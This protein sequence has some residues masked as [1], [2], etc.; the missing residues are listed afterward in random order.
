[1]PLV[2]KRVFASRLC[3]VDALHAVLEELLRIAEPGAARAGA[4][5]AHGV[6]SATEP[7]R[8]ARGRRANSRR[9]HCSA[10]SRR[11][12]AAR[13]ARRTDRGSRRR[14]RRAVGAS[15][16]RGGAGAACSAELGG[17]R[18]VGSS[19]S[20]SSALSFA[21][22]GGAAA[23]LAACVRGRVSAGVAPRRR[24]RA[25]A[26]AGWGLRCGARCGGAPSRQPWQPRPSPSPHPSGGACTRC[27]AAGRA[28][29]PHVRCQ[30]AAERGGKPG[31]HLLDSFSPGNSGY[32][33]PA[34]ASSAIVT[35][36]GAPK[37]GRN[38]CRPTKTRPLRRHEALPAHHQRG[39]GGCLAA[40]RR[41]ARSCAQRAQQPGS[42][43]C[44]A[45][46]AA[47]GGRRGAAV[48]LLLSHQHGADV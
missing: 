45:S 15:G 16:R 17:Q 27:A 47:A 39:R 35:R 30:D 44:Y 3:S 1:M 34:S 6:A 10:V 5:S 8:A 42:P 26:T 2:G 28:R 38:L 25:P 22:F 33:L 31:P 36:P 7:Q 32:S 13:R 48:A 43:D 46:R 21:S 20:A 4:Q 9:A 41:L 19:S 23:A 24:K 37:N 40:R 11:R 18:T 29:Q 14:G 12:A